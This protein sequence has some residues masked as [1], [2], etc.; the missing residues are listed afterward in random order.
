MDQ[1]LAVD[2]TLEPQPLS[3]QASMDSMDAPSPG[4][5]SFT[6]V[7]LPESHHRQPKVPRLDRRPSQSMVPERLLGVAEQ[8]RIIDQTD[9][10]AVI[11]Q[12][13]KKDL[14][15][16][17]SQIRD[18]EKE[19]SPTPGHRRQHTVARAGGPLA[20][21]A[22]AACAPAHRPVICTG[23]RPMPRRLLPAH[24]VPLS[25]APDPSPA[26]ICARPTSPPQTT[27]ELARDEGRDFFRLRSLLRNL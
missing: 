19:R 24:P 17:T 12:L 5:F 25:P 8:L 10:A 14:T 15:N 4:R 27:L 11:A 26:R 16:M 21:S 18:I 9:D 23:T 13:R 7:P 2:E 3:P 20:A 1:L 6:Q 22:N